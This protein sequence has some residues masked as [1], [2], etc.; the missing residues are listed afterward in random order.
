MLG[1]PS[2]RLK[3]TEREADYS[4]LV[5]RLLMDGVLHMLRCDIPWP[6]NGRIYSL[7]TCESLPGS[8]GSSVGIMT[9]L[10]DILAR[11]FSSA[12]NQ[13]RLCDPPRGTRGT[14]AEV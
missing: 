4:Y 2:L 11:N 8:R 5:P 3:R 1:V 13:E 12:K 14:E 6:V 7:A 9:T 10:R